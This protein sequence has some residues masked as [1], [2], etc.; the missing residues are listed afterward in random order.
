M[1]K[2]NQERRG[3]IHLYNPKT[4]GLGAYDINYINANK[5]NKELKEPSKTSN[6]MRYVA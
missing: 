6:K 3:F 2:N 4:E 1:N 5:Q